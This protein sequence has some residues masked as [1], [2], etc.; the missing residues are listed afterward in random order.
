MGFMGGENG[1]FKL[2]YDLAVS[3]SGKVYVV[4]V[5]NN[6]VQVFDLDGNFINK[7]NPRYPTGIAIDKFENVYVTA[8]NYGPT[9]HNVQKFD[10]NGNFIKEWGSYG[11][12]K[13]QF[14]APIG[15]TV[16]SSGNVY[17]ADSENNRIQIFDLNGTYQSSWG[18]YGNGD[19]QFNNP[20]DVYIDH[21]EEVYVADS[22]N[23][24]IQKFNKYGSFITKFGDYG[25]ENGQFNKTF[26]IAIRINPLEIS[27]S[28]VYVTDVYNHRVQKFSLIMPIGDTTSPIVSVENYPKHPEFSQQVNITAK[29]IDYSGISEINLFFWSNYSNSGSRIKC[30]FVQGCMYSLGPIFSHNSIIYYYA[31]AFDNSTNQNLG[32]DPIN[33]EKSFTVN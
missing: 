2:P 11:S 30:R 4:D 6:R 13:G 19:G 8:L 1:R 16:S 14:K 23:N 17:V 15:I 32:R 25:N 20:N 22:D 18:Y 27:N 33:G 5:Y 29:A 26:G 21:N 10:S 28:N 24:R 31:T 7:W 3:S 9:I 12:N